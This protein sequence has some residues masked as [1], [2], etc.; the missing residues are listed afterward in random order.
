MLILRVLFRIGVDGKLQRHGRRHV[1]LFV[2]ISGMCSK[3][4]LMRP[5]TMQIAETK[6][7]YRWHETRYR[8]YIHV[9]HIRHLHT[10]EWKV[11]ILNRGILQ[12]RIIVQVGFILRL[13]LLVL[14][15]SLLIAWLWYYKPLCRKL[16]Y[17]Y[18]IYQTE[19]IW[20]ARETTGTTKNH[21]RS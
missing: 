10:I 2:R 7:C 12:Y 17:M 18:L 6:I 21:V 4:A 14:L 9:W 20:I 19:P 15:S 1:S 13:A 8:S 11:E 3:I 16:S 5:L